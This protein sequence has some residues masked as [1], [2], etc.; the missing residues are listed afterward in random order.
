MLHLLDS[1]QSFVIA[2][3]L[4]TVEINGIPSPL[5]AIRPQDNE[6]WTRYRTRLVFLPPRGQTAL[7]CNFSY[8]TNVNHYV[9]PRG[10]E[11]QW[12]TVPPPAPPRLTE[13]RP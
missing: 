8:F 1:P 2:I 7:V 6:P 10:Y 4:E 5:Y 3:Q 9:M 13:P 12:T 11:T